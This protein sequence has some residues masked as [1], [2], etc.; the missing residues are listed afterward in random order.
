M[1][2]GARERIEKLGRAASPLE[3]KQEMS[4]LFLRSFQEP[5]P[6]ARSGTLW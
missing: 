6:L 2:G 4:F 1:A 5:E 3:E